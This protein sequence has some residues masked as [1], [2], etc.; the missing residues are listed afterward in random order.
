MPKGFFVTATD[1]G[2]GKTVI[3]AA[4]IK[5]A[6]MLG[7][8]AGGMKPIETGCLSS[9]SE[10]Q[11]PKFEVQNKNLIPADGLFLKEIAGM[12]DS[13]DLITP[14]RFEKPLAPLPASEIEG[15]EVDL[16]KIRKAYSILTGK[17]DVVIV[18][19]I[20][21]LFVPIRRD[22]F[23]IDLAREFGLPLIVV[24]RPG[25]GTINHTLLTVNYALKE[26]VHV[27]GIIMNYTHTPERDL[28]EKTNQEVIKQIS[29]APIIGTFPYLKDLE[30]STIE[31]AVI[32]NLN[33]EIL[34]KYL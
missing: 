15:A 30:S 20:G 3:T 7:F 17:Y 23:I 31:K 34:K 13:M 19:G 1:T 18:E 26:G 2:V 8:R 10:V 5:I 14:I 9:N 21:G 32:K 11:I 6:G 33:F 12:D 28:A 4:L 27:A 24:A 29:S 22:Y 25:L 16:E